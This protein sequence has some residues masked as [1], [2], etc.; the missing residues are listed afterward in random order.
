MSRTL[1]A[2]LHIPTAVL[3]TLETKSS[4]HFRTPANMQSPG[5]IKT[6]FLWPRVQFSIYFHPFAHCSLSLLF[7]R[8]IIR[9]VE[10]TMTKLKGNTSKNTKPN[11]DD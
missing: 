7:F 1:L 4:H 3:H 5:T 9:T 10:T 2:H 11:S 6:E 8:M